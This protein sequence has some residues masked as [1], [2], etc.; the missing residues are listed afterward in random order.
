M[1][2]VAE[3]LDINN[4]IVT[5][6]LIIAIDILVCAVWYFTQ[7]MKRADSLICNVLFSFALT[8]Y[9]KLFRIYSMEAVS[10]LKKAS[11]FYTKNIYFL[12]SNCSYEKVELAVT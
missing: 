1:Q 4:D 7:M 12:N 6:I 9:Q 2:T 10:K 8:P 11:Q 3:Q 5:V